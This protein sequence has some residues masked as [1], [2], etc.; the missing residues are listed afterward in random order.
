MLTKRVQPWRSDNAE[1]AGKL[2]RMH[3]RRADIADLA[4][5]HDVVQRLQRLLDRRL[6]VPAMDLVEVDVIGAEAAQ[7]GVEL[8]HDRL[9]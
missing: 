9:A 4:C 6:V 2:P 3:R 7:A 8:S 5:L 1:R